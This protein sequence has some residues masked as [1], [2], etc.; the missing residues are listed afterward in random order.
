VAS[1]VEV[2]RILRPANASGIEGTADAQGPSLVVLV[3][4]DTAR[5]LAYAQAFAK[6]VVT[7]D[8]PGTFTPPPGA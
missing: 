3:D 5:E 1:G 7:I 4:P 2:A 8:P 6:L